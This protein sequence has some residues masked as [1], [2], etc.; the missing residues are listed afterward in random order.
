[1]HTNKLILFILFLFPH[2]VFS[3]EN[4]P[5]ILWITC[6]DIS[7][8]VGAYGDSVA[9]TPN[10][11]RLAS[12]GIRFD[13]A[14][15]VAGVCSPSR[16]AIITGVY[17]T[18]IGAHNMRVNW[19]TPE[20]IDPY[21]VV[22]PD[23][24]HCFT[25]YLRKEGYFCTNNYKTDYQFKAPFTAWDEN[26]KQAHWRHREEGQPFFS[27][28]NIMTTH[29]SMLW[30]NADHELIVPAEQVSVPAY[31][32]DTKTVR[33]DIARNYANI[34]EMD[35]EVGK[36]LAQL[37][38]DGLMDNTIIFFYSDHGGPLPRQKREINNGGLQVPFLVRYPD[39]HG[40]GTTNDELVSFLD[41]APTVL[42]LAGIAP[43]KYMDGR[44]FLGEQKQ[45]EPTYLFAARDRMDKQYD[46]SRA[47]RDKQFV[48]IKNYHPE[49]PW[50]M[51]VAY[52]KSI[53]M[54]REMLEM[55][56]AGTLNDIQMQ[57]FNPTKPAEQLFDFT[58]DP[59][60]VHN[61]IDD[62]KY[63]A[64]ADRM[65][66][67]LDRW[68]QENID[69]GATPEPEIY[70]EM[71]P[72]RERPSSGTV[73]WVYKE[74]KG[75]EIEHSK[76]GVSLGY[77]E[78]GAERWQIFTKAITFDQLG[79]YRA[80]GIHIG[81]EES[82][83]TLPLKGNPLMTK[84]VKKLQLEVEGQVISGKNPFE[85]LFIFSD[86]GQLLGQSND[87]K[88]TFDI[89]E[90]EQVI[91]AFVDGQELLIQ[92]VSLNGNKKNQKNIFFTEPLR[93]K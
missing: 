69:L 31:F 14:C 26:G 23:D 19:F 36:L 30:K 64:V 48:Y 61:L 3:Q 29:E 33:N 85:K 81:C 84:N 75:F 43:K 46:R 1:M 88:F 18:K 7:C 74:G 83:T 27:V 12:E 86:Q 93:G 60:E 38:A 66:K 90:N 58:K 24:I 67:A 2:L 80:K 4:K 40:A 79:H 10:I 9:I 53:P 70:Q 51:D 17:P 16:A 15:S 37:E 32:P 47:V 52:R 92:E 22:A 59:D 44:V 45:P 76:Q 50:Y 21:E 62:P 73:R 11:D 34:F 8:N 39:Q 28:F 6:E 35:Q 20:G 72:N 57:W 77:Q 91:L 56:E 68:E 82:P 25:E 89:G 54:M 5:N 55:K 65:R 63:K 49:K 78:I 13:N 42:D 87:K 71:W 41:L